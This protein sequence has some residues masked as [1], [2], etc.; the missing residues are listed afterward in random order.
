[1]RGRTVIEIAHNASAI[2]D[3][4][5]VIVLDQGQIVAVGTR[6]E[7]EKSNAFYRQLIWET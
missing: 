4:D 7:L 2:Q 1:M 6:E 3:A 5:N